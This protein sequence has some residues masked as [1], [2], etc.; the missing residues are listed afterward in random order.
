VKSLKIDRKDSK[1]NS[2]TEKGMLSTNSQGGESV[3]TTNIPIVFCHPIC[4][5]HPT[6]K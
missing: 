1:E 5:K 4:A 3:S 6:F 2:P